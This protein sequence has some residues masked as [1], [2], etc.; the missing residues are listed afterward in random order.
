FVEMQSWSIGRQ[1]KRALVADEMNF[2]A[3]P[4]QV[5]AQRRGEY[6][7]AADRGVTGDADSEAL[8]HRRS[9]LSQPGKN[10]RRGLPPPGQAR[11]LVWLILIG[12]LSASKGLSYGNPCWRGWISKDAGAKT[13]RWPLL[14]G[15]KGFVVVCRTLAV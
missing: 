10:E 13:V 2:M 4:G 12:V 7:A 3:A 1:P 14:G 9:S 11:R 5:F 6:A 8:V 15:C